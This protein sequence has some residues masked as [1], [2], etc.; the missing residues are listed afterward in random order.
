V[1]RHLGEHVVDRF[2]GLLKRGVAGESM[3]GC[4][5]LAAR[6]GCSSVPL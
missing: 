1:S 4:I 3:A 6:W 5:C 2:D